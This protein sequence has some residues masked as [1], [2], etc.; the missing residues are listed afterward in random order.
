MS[1]YSKLR[2]RLCVAT[3]LTVVVLTAS[4]YLF[5]AHIFS[6]LNSMAK[7]LG[8]IPELPCQVSILHEG[9]RMKDR[10]LERL[11]ISLR[12]EQCFPLLS[13][14]DKDL[15]VYP[16]R[17]TEGKY[18][19][20]VKCDKVPNSDGPVVVTVLEFPDDGSIEAYHLNADLVSTGNEA[21]SCCSVFLSGRREGLIVW[22]NQ[23]GGQVR[24][25]FG[26]GYRRFY[27]H[28]NKGEQ[29]LLLIKEV[30]LER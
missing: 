11:S 9:P 25:P 13:N 3:L 26:I 7:G 18:A 29:R 2:I 21:E 16:C 1:Y 30:F 4:C 6:P 20:G 17:T 19:L 28:G 12:K 5:I 8:N 15:A 22:K 24:C 14:K 10:D 23:K 27:M